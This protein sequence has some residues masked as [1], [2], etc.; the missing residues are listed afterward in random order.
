M[1]I[2]M[3]QCPGSSP[4]PNQ[5]LICFSDAEGVGIAAV[6]TVSLLE[7]YPGATKV[8]SHHVFPITLSTHPAVRR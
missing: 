6:V 1:E 3:L 2:H 7:E 4:N 8:R 5:V